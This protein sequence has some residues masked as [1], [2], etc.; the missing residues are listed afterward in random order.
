MKYWSGMTQNP[1]V[2]Q[3]LVDY[4]DSSENKDKN[5]RCFWKNYEPGKDNKVRVNLN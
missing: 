2:F 5:T 3:L 1:P 4:D